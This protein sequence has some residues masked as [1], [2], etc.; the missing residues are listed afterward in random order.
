MGFENLE[1]LNWN[2]LRAF[3]FKEGAR[4]ETTNFKIPDDFLLDASFSVSSDPEL[5]LY[6]SKISTNSQTI[7]LEISDNAAVVVGRFTLTVSSHTRNKTYFLTPNEDQYIGASGRIT[8]GSVSSILNQASGVFSF[9]LADTVFEMRTLVPSIRKINR[10]VFHDAKK[11]PFSLT[12]SVELFAN[13]NLRFAQD[14]GEEQQIVARLDAANT[15]GLSKTCPVLPCVRSINGVG[16]DDDGLLTISG[17]DCVNVTEGVNTIL[18]GD[19]C[20]QPCL[21]CTDLSTLTSRVVQVE[22]D[23]LQ[24]KEYYVNLGLVKDQLTTL[25][26]FNCNCVA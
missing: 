19:T 20:C 25:I 17:V 13:L 11:K 10:I 2:S 22:T 8:V 4:R 9:A 12:D 21:G 7:I 24:L 1:F 5:E 15:F 14:T 6:I 16:P 18:I 23:L 3:P 26:N